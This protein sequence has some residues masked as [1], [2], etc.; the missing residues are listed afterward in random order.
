MGPWPGEK[1]PDMWNEL[2]KQTEAGI[3]NAIKTRTNSF[4][5]ARALDRAQG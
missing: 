4:S 3:N 1:G 5:E 2:G